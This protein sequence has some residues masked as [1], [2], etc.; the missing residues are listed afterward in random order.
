MHLTLQTVFAVVSR[1]IS[2]LFTV[3]LDLK[4]H[5]WENKLTSEIVPIAND[6]S[7]T[8]QDFLYEE[9]KTSDREYTSKTIRGNVRTIWSFSFAMN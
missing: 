3:R 7:E 5:I 9:K 2:T 1:H 6:L 4:D 8:E